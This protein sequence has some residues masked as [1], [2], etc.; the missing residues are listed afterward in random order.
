MSDTLNNFRIS[1]ILV[2]RITASYSGNCL[3]DLIEENTEP[4]HKLWTL[5]TIGIDPDAVN[6][7]DVIACN[8]Y[9]DSVQFKDGKY[10]IRLPWKID[11]EGLLNI[12]I[13]LNYLFLELF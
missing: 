4:V 5:D 10:F 8:N 13:L 11:K 7:D 6:K 2:C 12:Q 9:I 3:P 1:K